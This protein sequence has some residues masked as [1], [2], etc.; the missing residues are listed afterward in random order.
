MENFDELAFNWDNE[1]KRIER[2]R[3]VTDE[4]IA[5]IPG[6][7]K[8]NAMEYGCGTGVLSFCLQPYLKHITLGDNSQGMLDVLVGKIKNAG[9]K[10]MAPMLL[11]LTEGEFKDLK[12]D[13]IYSLMALHHILDTDRIIDSFSKILNPGGTLCIADLDEEDGTFH[14]KGFNGHNGFNR[15]ELTDKM[16]QYGFE[17][18]RW[19]ICYNNTKMLENGLEKQYPMFLMIGEKKGETTED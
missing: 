17:N 8:M 3:I 15:Y 2:A 14:D 18:I 10:N 13:M 5:A 12:F 9:V 7:D 16:I 4:I 19:K 1:P 6:L 11:D